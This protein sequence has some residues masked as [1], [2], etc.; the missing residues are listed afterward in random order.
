MCSGGPAMCHV[1]RL[2][3]RREKAEAT[4]LDPRGLGVPGGAPRAGASLGAVGAEPGPGSGR[5]RR[6]RGC[7]RAG[8]SRDCGWWSFLRTRVRTRSET[9]RLGRV[10]RPRRSR[11]PRGTRRLRPRR[12]ARAEASRSDE[13]A[14]FRRVARRRDRRRARDA[15]RAAQT[16]EHEVAERDRASRE[17]AGARGDVRGVSGVQVCRRRRRAIRG[18]PGG[19]RSRSLA[20]RRG[21]A[22]RGGNAR[23]FSS[24]RGARRQR[25][26]AEPTRCGASRAGAG[27]RRRGDGGGSRGIPRSGGR[28]S[29][30][31]SA[32]AGCVTAGGVAIMSTRDR[33]SLSEPRY[34]DRISR[35]RFTV[36]DPT[37]HSPAPLTSTRARAWRRAR[38]SGAEGR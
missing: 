19:E 36:R 7:R 17:A 15:R 21:G 22:R 1:A 14:A 38:T 28:R 5:V 4:S 12:G 11:R 32:V 33:R 31:R 35:K 26:T 8:I 25:R 24:W 9:I 10:R 6:R 13:R 29:G 3:I 34:S 27:R 37:W 18:E 2:R 30:R 23:R 16:R 20:R